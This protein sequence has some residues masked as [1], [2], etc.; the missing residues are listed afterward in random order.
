MWG[1]VML[2]ENHTKSLRIEQRVTILG[3]SE[4]LGSL[5]QVNVADRRLWRF[6]G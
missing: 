1:G 2:E 5:L 6:K 3:L 4:C